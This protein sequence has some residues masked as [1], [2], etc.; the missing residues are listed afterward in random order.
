MFHR[1]RT[2]IKDGDIKARRIDKIN[3]ANADGQL[4]VQD[5]A[6]SYFCIHVVATVD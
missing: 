2:A 5:S 6:I 3:Y 4:D 1:V